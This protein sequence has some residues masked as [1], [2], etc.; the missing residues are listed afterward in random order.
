[1]RAL[2][3]FLV[4]FLHSLPVYSWRRCCVE[5]EAGREFERKQIGIAGDSRGRFRR[6]ET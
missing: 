5:W 3:R 6:V 1:M 2:R 4:W